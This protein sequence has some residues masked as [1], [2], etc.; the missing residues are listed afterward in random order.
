MN[1]RLVSTVP[2][3]PTRRPSLLAVSII[4]A[5]VAFGYRYTSLSGFS[6]DNFLHL[7]RAQAMLAGDLPIRDY[8]EEGLPLMVLLSAAAQL[9]FGQSLFAEAMLVLV[10]LSIAAGVTCWL[11]SRV[12][13]SLLLGA[14]AALLQVLVYPRLYSYP[15]M[16]LYAVLP[17]DCLVVSQRTGPSPS[18]G[19][20]AVDRGLVSDAPRSWR[21]HRPGCGGCDCGRVTGGRASLSSLVEGWIRNPDRGLADAVFG[22]RAGPAGHHRLFSYRTSRS[23]AAKHR[24]R[25][26]GA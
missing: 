19:A 2:I 20:R 23:A 1:Q 15:K 7:A 11:A 4:V 5:V 17:A 24:E 21:L 9:V 18:R 14:G 3:A 6:N 16:L 8:T 26:S 13:G 12:T 22:L 10:S 25:D